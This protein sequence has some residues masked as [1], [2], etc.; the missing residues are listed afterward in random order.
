M[1]MSRFQET[2]R[3]ICLAQAN[4]SH[5]NRAKVG[6]VITKNNR[7]ISTGWNG[8]PKGYN[9]NCED[10]N[11]ETKIEVLHAE[12]NA[13]SAMLRHG[14][15]SRDCDLYVTLSPCINCAKLIANAGISRVYYWE[16]YRLNDGINLL[17]KLGVKV[18]KL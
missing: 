18:I 14:I 12:F 6:C 4:M 9:N 16:D 8:M 17:Q 10:E 1:A 11:G 15:A 3:Q 2:M 7:I 13:L 5:A